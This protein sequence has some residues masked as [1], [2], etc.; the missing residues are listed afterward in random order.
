MVFP[1][2]LR[3]AISLLGGGV[4]REPKESEQTAQACADYVRNL[5]CSTVRAYD[6]VSL[7]TR[8]HHT[9][10]ITLCCDSHHCADVDA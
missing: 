4:K 7:P 5:I 8:L 3:F 9:F 6:S 1:G 10:T 2:G